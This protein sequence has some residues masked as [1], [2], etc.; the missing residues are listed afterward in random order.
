[1]VRLLTPKFRRFEVEAIADEVQ[2][3]GVLDL[4]PAKRHKLA[5]AA[6]LQV[7][8]AMDDAEPARRRFVSIYACFVGD[9]S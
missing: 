5:Q 3:T 8:G 6:Q 2:L 4:D 1:M 7:I 9:C